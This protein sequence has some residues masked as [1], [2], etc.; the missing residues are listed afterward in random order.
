MKKHAKLLMRTVGLAALLWG[1][2]AQAALL[3]YTTQSSFITAT[4]ALGTKHLTNFDSTPVDT[5]FANGTG[6]AGSQFTL[7]S[8]TFVTDDTPSVQDQFWTTSGTR[9]LGLDNA[10][11]QFSNGDTLTFTLSGSVRAFGLYVIAGTTDYSLGDFGLT[12]GGNTLSS[13]AADESDGAGGSSAFFLGFTSDVDITSAVLNFGAP[14][15]QK[16]FFNAAVD[17]VT[18]F[19]KAGTTPPDPDPGTVPEP[20]SLVLLGV[21]GLALTA[22][23]RLGR[24]S[25]TRQEQQS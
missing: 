24:Q 10:D 14:G 8:T 22:T 4:A 11:A 6:P 17:D 7:T 18:L 20:S 1:G 2:A 19:D 23:R 15:E 21:A 25:S 5:A 3:T 12:V 16:F 9:Y 13:A